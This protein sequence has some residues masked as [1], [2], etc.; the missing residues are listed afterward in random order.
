MRQLGWLI[1]LP[2]TLEGLC[3]IALY[4]VRRLKIHRGARMAEPRCSKFVLHAAANLATRILQ[5]LALIDFEL[6][7]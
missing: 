5:S 6:R 2:Q 4:A 3:T 1:R 7:G